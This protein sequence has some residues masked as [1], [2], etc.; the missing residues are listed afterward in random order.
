MDAISVHI[1]NEVSAFFAPAQSFIK[2]L[3]RH[4]PTVKY[5]SNLENINISTTLQKVHG[6]LLSFSLGAVITVAFDLSPVLVDRVLNDLTGLSIFA[7]EFNGELFDRGLSQVMRMNPFTFFK[8]MLLPTTIFSFVL[9]DECLEQLKNDVHSSYGQILSE[10]IALDVSVQEARKMGVVATGFIATYLYGPSSYIIKSIMTL[11]IFHRVI[12]NK[13]KVSDDELIK[14]GVIIAGCALSAAL[15]P[16]I[17]VIKNFSALFLF[18]RSF[19]PTQLTLADFRSLGI[20]S[21]G[22]SLLQYLFE[23]RG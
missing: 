18:H 19:L 3:T 23:R 13:E 4:L 14:T 15:L 10:K 9:V 5:D 20:A 1:P 16:Q 6:F 11:S 22:F 7:E 17:T 21:F 2:D 12:V 8:L